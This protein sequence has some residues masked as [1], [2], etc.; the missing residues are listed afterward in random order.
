MLF[1][2]LIRTFFKY[3]AQFISMIIMVVLGI[4]IFAGFNAEWYSIEKDTT[5]FFNE[6]NL[7]DYRIYNEKKS[8]SEDDLNNVLSID[9]ID[10]ATRYICID[11]SESKEDD[12]IKLAI[13]ENFTVSNF[14]LMEG[15]PYNKQNS[16]GVWLSQKYALNNNY[17]V[18]DKI[19]LKYGSVTKTLNIEGICLSSEF[20]INTHGT[21]LMPDYNK[22][23]YAYSTPAF[24][25]ELSNELFNLTYYPQINIISSLSLDEVSTKVDEKLNSTLQIISKDDVTSYSQAQGELEEGKTIAFILP[26]IFLLIA[27][28]TM[29]TTMNRITT[30][31]KMQI[32]ILK[33]LG[34]KNKKIINHYTSYAFVIG[35]V[36]SI[37]GLGLGYIVANIFFSP[38]GSMGTYFEMPDWT[39]HIPWFTY[40]G[41]ILIVLL[42]TIIGYL[43]VK[44][45][46][47]GSA[48]E[49]LRPYEPKK[50]KNMLIEKTKLFHKFNFSIR[51][52]LRDSLRHKARTFMSIFGV[53]GCTLLLFA[54]FGMKSTM[55]NYIDMNYSTV[56]NYQTSLT[57]SDSIT[58]ERA[59]QL[60]SLYQ[61][62]YSSTLAS[63]VEGTTYVMTILNNHTDKVRLIEK[64]TAIKELSS[65]GIYICERM[66]EDLN[67][68]VGDTCKFSLYGQSTKYEV[69]VEK[70]VS[71]STKGFTLTYDLADELNLPY[72][73]DTIYTNT[74]KS[75]ITTNNE[76]VSLS[77]KEDLIKTFDTFM[78]IMNLMIY[79]LVL[80]SSLLAFVVLYNLGTMSYIER[81]REL[82][83][84][85]VLG[86][87]NSK[88]RWILTSQNIFT[89][90]IGIIIGCP[91]GYVTLVGLYK[92][93]A[94]EYELSIVCSWYVYFISIII[95]FLVSFIV[96]YFTSLKV[97]KINMVEALK[98]E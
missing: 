41:I 95:T 77:S 46:L 6:T 24:Y 53:F 30:N 51:Y 70:I 2:K 85:K 74:L 31:E 18:G 20:L 17:K 90:L 14:K 9:G 35:L 8:F 93:L 48:A 64:T 80:F 29:I 91:I 45:Q 55:N 57:L 98:A 56:M 69:K 72:K 65:S 96:S 5:N 68:K 19:T 23:G 49:A 16:N 36:G 12:I 34:F 54:T 73:I 59:K 76:I 88:I 63:K 7:A 10:K 84:L 78:E 87:K 4:G 47:K 38:S 13:S 97:K 32:G 21:A 43:S 25:E 81:Y 79:V 40:V 27:I 60:A 15:N 75:Q 83:T 37:I 89:T 1:K 66:A 58:N 61:G 11:T 39:I 50:M 42:L 52:N 3:K 86:F 22:V 33:A 44:Q 26:S 82:A 28:L 67:L 62:D 92:A 71:S 94:S